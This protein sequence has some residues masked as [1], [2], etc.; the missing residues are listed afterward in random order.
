MVVDV[1]KYKG[2]SIGS[3]DISD[4]M[5]NEY[6]LEPI[7]RSPNIRKIGQCSVFVYEKEGMIP[8]MHIA[9]KG[10]NICVCL[11]TNK[12]F[13][14]DNRFVQFSNSKQRRDF[15]NW[16]RQQNIK[17]AKEYG[18]GYITNYEAAAYVWNDLNPKARFTIKEQPDYCSMTEEIQKNK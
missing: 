3:I 7:E 8:H 16:L 5:I 2:V 4:L 1:T 15:D 14:H 13:S 9:S 18:L 10:I 17:V 11:H 12:Y 6:A